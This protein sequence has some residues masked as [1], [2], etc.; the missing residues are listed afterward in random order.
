MGFCDGRA[1]ARKLQ[2]AMNDEPSDDEAESTPAE[3]ALAPTPDLPVDNGTGG[4]GGGAVDAPAQVEESSSSTS[5]S[6]VD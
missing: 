3:P 6:E 2:R 1:K 5:A 4:L